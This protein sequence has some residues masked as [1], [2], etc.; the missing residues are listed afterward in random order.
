MVVVLSMWQVKVYE[1]MVLVFLWLLIVS[2]LL[3]SFVGGVGA[4]CICIAGFG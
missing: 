3:K 2:M 4:G 1:E